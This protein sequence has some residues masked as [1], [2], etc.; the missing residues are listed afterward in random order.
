MTYV[1]E[2]VLQPVPIESLRPTQIT[3]GMREVEEKRKRLRKQKPRKIGGFIGHHMIPVVLGPKKRHYVIDHHHLSL[4]LHKEGLRDVLVTVVLDLSALEPDAFWNVLDHKSLVYPFDPQGRRRDFADI[5]KTVMQLKDDP[6][7]SLAG[8]LRRAGGFAKDTTPFSEFLWADFFR[9]KIKRK[10]VEADFSAA[11]ERALRLARSE[12][13]EYLPA[14]A[15]PR[16]TRDRSKRLT[17]CTLR[18]YFRPPPKALRGGA[19]G[20]CRRAS[21][22]TLRFADPSPD[23]LEPRRQRYPRDRHHSHDAAHLCGY[24]L[25]PKHFRGAVRPPVEF[26][27]HGAGRQFHGTRPTATGEPTLPAGVDSARLSA[28][29]RSIPQEGSARLYPGRY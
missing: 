29:D 14:G 12:E 9:R 1:R 13:A 15:A 10:A 8:E 23:R 3:V 2:P 11:M 27:C 17:P 21:R 16:P 25:C 5:P 19:P 28:P 26:S 22:G 7:R 6:F 4:A 18:S 24:G 20:D